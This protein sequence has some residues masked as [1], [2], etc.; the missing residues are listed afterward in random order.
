MSVSV[1]L[2]LTTLPTASVAA[3]SKD[4]VISASLKIPSCFFNSEKLY[5][6][7]QAVLD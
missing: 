1:I 2:P 7:S 5:E 3:H 4:S 6:A